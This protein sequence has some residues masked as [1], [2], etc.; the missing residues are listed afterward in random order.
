MMLERNGVCV[1]Y[2]NSSRESAPV[3]VSRFYIT[4][5]PRLEGLFLVSDLRYDPAAAD[6]SRPLRLIE[7]KPVTPRIER[8]AS[9]TDVDQV[10][11]NA[12]RSKNCRQ[13]G[14]ERQLI[15]GLLLPCKK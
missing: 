12:F 1:A 3:D 9:W 13:G 4:G 2:G 14:A 8:E 11:K 6:L 15:G 5:R 7:A 10:A